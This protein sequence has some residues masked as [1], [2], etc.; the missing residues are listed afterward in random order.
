[1]GRT[2]ERTERAPVG[3]TAP[4][5]EALVDAVIDARFPRQLRGYDPIAVD[6]LLDALVLWLDD[7]CLADDPVAR[8]TLPTDLISGRA[9]VALLERRGPSSGARHDRTV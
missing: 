5:P 7:L 2:S 6:A 1:M 8:A 4:S 3:P 9:A